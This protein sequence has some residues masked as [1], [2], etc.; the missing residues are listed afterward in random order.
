MFT[1]GKRIKTYIVYN[2]KN[3]CLGFS[4]C[5]RYVHLKLVYSIIFDMFEFLTNIFVEHARRVGFQGTFLT[6]FYNCVTSY[7]TFVE[8]TSAVEPKLRIIDC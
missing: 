6:S 5:I 7:Y 2:E 3:P 8:S 4:R 1:V